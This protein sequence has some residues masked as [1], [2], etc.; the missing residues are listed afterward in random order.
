AIGFQSPSI[1]D[2][3][4][5]MTNPI[6]NVVSLPYSEPQPLHLK[7]PTWALLLRVLADSHLSRFEPSME[8]SAQIEKC[9]LRTVVQFVKSSPTSETWHTVLWFT[10]DQPVPAVHPDAEKYSSNDPSVLPFSYSLSTLPA[11]LQE[12]GDNVYAIPKTELNSWPVLPIT[13]PNV[14]LYLL[15]TFQESK[16]HE[17]DSTNALGKLAR[18]ITAC[19]P[20]AK[21]GP[22]SVA[23]Q[24]E[25]KGSLMRLSRKF[26]IGRGTKK[27]GTGRT[28]ESQELITPFKSE[29]FS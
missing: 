11:L 25:P 7:S 22:P 5:L 19:Y 23:E 3:L 14:A 16:T 17:H 24:E 12:A 6:P 28:P 13:F 9:Q 20:S 10:I 21:A 4:S 2:D 18:L 1:T 26:G 8:A 29:E 15:A 27:S